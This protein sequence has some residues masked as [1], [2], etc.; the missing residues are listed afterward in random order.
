[1]FISKEHFRQQDNSAGNNQVKYSRHFGC[2]RCVHVCMLANDVLFFF[3]FVNM[4]LE[5]LTETGIKI[6][7]L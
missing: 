3:F 5:V 7:V 4:M 1:M 2:S 6:T